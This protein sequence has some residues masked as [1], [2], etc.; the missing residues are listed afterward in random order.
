MNYC[1]VERDLAAYERKVEAED[2]L[3]EARD[4]AIEAEYQ[5]MLEQPL[6]CWVAE[7]PLMHLQHV[8]RETLPIGAMANRFARIDLESIIRAI[9]EDRVSAERARGVA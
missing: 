1:V 2:R 6:S 4:M 5:A 3:E 8:C 7:T 9:A